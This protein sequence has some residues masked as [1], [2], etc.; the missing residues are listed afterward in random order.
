MKMWIRPVYS[1]SSLISFALCGSNEKL[2]VDS[3][4]VEHF[5]V[6]YNGEEITT[7]AKEFHKATEVAWGKPIDIL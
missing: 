1:K 7:S 3:Q 4:I 6:D 5:E 2:L